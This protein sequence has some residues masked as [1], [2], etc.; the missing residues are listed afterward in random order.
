MEQIEHK[1]WT[2]GSSPKVWRYVSDDERT[3]TLQ[4]F[5][6]QLED[7]SSCWDDDPDSQVLETF[8]NRARHD[9]HATY[10]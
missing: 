5:R 2:G 7:W 6:E 8:W 9:A 3:Y 10:R 1:A 4:L